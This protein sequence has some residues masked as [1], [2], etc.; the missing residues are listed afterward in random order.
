MGST[1]HLKSTHGSG[2]VLE[3]DVQPSTTDIFDDDAVATQ[4]RKVN[5]LVCGQLFANAECTE[6]FGRHCVYHVP[7]TSV[8]R[9]SDVFSAL[10][11]SNVSCLRFYQDAV[12]FV[13]LGCS[14]IIT[15][16][17][18]KVEMLS[19]LF[20]ALTNVII[21]LIMRQWLCVVVKQDGLISEYSFSQSTLEQVTAILFAFH[22]CLLLLCSDLATNILF[23]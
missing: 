13:D 1:Q 17:H 15:S 9:L 3:V 21:Q 7:Q 6:Q 5:D 8:K 22:F 4:Q 10:Q 19:Q 23:R 11:Q 16:V 12:R 2:Y 14:E 18:R 20:T